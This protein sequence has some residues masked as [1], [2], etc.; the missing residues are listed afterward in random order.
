MTLMN[1]E[2]NILKGMIV[3]LMMQILIMW[4]QMT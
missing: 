1:L 2:K 4:R 3:I